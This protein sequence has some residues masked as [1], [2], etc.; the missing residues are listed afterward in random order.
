MNLAQMINGKNLFIAKPYNDGAIMPTALLYPSKA[1]VKVFFLSMGST[2][3]ATDNGGAFAC[4]TGQGGG[5]DAKSLAKTEF[6]R[7]NDVDIDENGNVFYK[8]SQDNIPMALKIV[9]EASKG[10]AELWVKSHFKSKKGDILRN[11]LRVKLKNAFNDN[12]FENYPYIGDSSKQYNFDFAIKQNGATRLIDIVTN[13]QNSINA[14]FVAH[15]DVKQNKSDNIEQFLAYDENDGWKS[16]D[17]LLL[18]TTA[19]L[20]SIQKPVSLMQI[21]QTVH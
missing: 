20:I 17:F 10:V 5:F 16:Q 15:Y 13:D 6:M 11:A 14:K 1:S 3:I 12:L 4:L 21:S 8:T 9:A 19:K 7:R 18:K 2:I